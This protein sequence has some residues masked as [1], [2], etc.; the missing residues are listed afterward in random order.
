VLGRLSCP[1][2]VIRTSAWAIPPPASV[3]RQ[4]PVTS[5]N[6]AAATSVSNPDVPED[7]EV[8]GD[9]AQVLVDLRLPGEPARPVR[10]G[11]ND[12]EYRWDGTSHPASG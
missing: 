1:V 7:V 11:A 2:A 8:A 3:S 9:V 5:S 12:S 6:A 4:R 10:L